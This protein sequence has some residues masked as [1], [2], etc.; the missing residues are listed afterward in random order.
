MSLLSGLNRAKVDNRKAEGCIPFNVNASPQGSTPGERPE[1][2]V[3]RPEDGVQA[4]LLAE[5]DPTMDVTRVNEVRNTIQNYSNKSW[6][7]KT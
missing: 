3:Y 1:G 4:R 2:Y 5:L 7:K 6:Q